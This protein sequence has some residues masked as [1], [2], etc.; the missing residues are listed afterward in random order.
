MNKEK[1]IFELKQQLT[2]NRKNDR[3]LIFQH[4]LDAIADGEVE[5]TKEYMRLALAYLPNELDDLMDEFVKYEDVYTPVFLNLTVFQ[6]VTLVKRMAL[7][8]FLTKYATEKEK[9]EKSEDEQLYA[10]DDDFQQQLFDKIT[11]GRIKYR[12]SEYPYAL[13]Y[14]QYGL[15]MREYG[16]NINAYTMLSKAHVWNPV[17]SVTIFQLLILFKQSRQ[18]EE[19]LR[20]SQWLL[21]VSYQPSFIA[22]ALQYMAYALYLDGKYEESYAF[23]FQSLKYDDKPF[24]GLNEEIN[25]VLTALKLDA[26]YNLSRVDV[27][28]IFIGKNYKPQPNELVFDTLREHIIISYT[29]QNYTEVLHFANSY[30]RIRPRDNKI[31]NIIK[32]STEA[33]N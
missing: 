6:E 21:T 23:Y 16:D 3:L 1:H 25:G 28:N 31:N 12:T 20:F 15:L 32:K 17:S 29:K 14:L 2:G 5:M 33:L 10:F 24:P 19:L 18:S 4:L 26:P 11:G 7:M 27:S 13:I 22:L 30:K 9:L 8:H